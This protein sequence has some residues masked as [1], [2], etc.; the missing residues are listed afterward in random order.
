[1]GP[2]KRLQSSLKIVAGRG[3][4]TVFH[5]AKYYF[6]LLHIISFDLKNHDNLPTQLKS[7]RRAFCFLF[8]IAK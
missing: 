4:F 6:G 3:R 7:G 2:S 1:M 5:K 8:I